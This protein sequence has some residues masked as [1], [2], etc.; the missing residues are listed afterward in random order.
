VAA[1]PTTGGQKRKP[2]RRLTPPGSSADRIIRLPPPPP[3]LTKRDREDTAKAVTTRLLGPPDGRIAPREHRDIIR[4]QVRTQV[5]PPAQAAREMRRR[6]TDTPEAL[7]RAGKLPRSGRT[8]LAETGDTKVVRSIFKGLGAIY[9]SVNPLTPANIA[10][11]KDQ[12][13]IVMDPNATRQEKMLAGLGL[14]AVAGGI[15]NPPGKP[16]IPK[17]GLSKKER[18]ARERA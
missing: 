13:K 5:L 10:Y 11:A 8:E 7:G 15:N 3:G 9:E 17:K 4:E 2:K 16:P 6:T 12:K 14:I 18:L 1:D